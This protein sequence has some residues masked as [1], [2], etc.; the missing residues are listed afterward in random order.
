V[1]Q[2]AKDFQAIGEMRGV[3]IDWSL[4]ER[5]LSQEASVRPAAA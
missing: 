1:E 3:G 5:R 2:W 4:V